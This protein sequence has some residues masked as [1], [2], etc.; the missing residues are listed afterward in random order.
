MKKATTC[1]IGVDVSKNKL[2][3]YYHPL[4]RLYLNEIEIW[5]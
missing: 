5:L 4:N 2:D 3:I 1:F